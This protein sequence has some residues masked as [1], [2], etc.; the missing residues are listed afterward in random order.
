MSIQLDFGSMHFKISAA[1]SAR[2]LINKIYC[3]LAL[4]IL[5]RHDVRDA[6]NDYWSTV[7]LHCT[8]RSWKVMRRY[9][10]MRIMRVNRFENNQNAPERMILD[11]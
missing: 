5:M 2:V 7:D 4:I 11:T 10:F 3:F 1:S 9:C 8:R 6:I